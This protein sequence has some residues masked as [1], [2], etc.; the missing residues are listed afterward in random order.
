MVAVS[1]GCTDGSC[2]GSRHQ[3]S[4]NFLDGHPRTS[5]SW[6]HCHCR[7]AIANKSTWLCGDSCILSPGSHEISH[8]G[9]L[10]P[11]ADLTPHGLS[12][13]RWGKEEKKGAEHPRIGSAI[14]HCFSDWMLHLCVQ[15]S[16]V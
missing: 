12:S 15:G 16:T 9:R 10:Q 14:W 6:P 2:R 8:D 4:Q 1:T 7:N 11:L 5:R 13:R 3:L